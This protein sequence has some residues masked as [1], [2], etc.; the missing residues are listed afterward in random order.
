MK[1]KDV[2]LLNEFVKG[3]FWPFMNDLEKVNFIGYPWEDKQPDTPILES[4]VFSNGYDRDYGTAYD[5]ETAPKT[6]HEV[7]EKSIKSLVEFREKYKD[8]KV[9]W[10]FGPKLEFYKGNPYIRYRIISEPLEKKGE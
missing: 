2:K 7:L 6:F 1:S 5:P 8:V 9:F 4:H 10:R 3:A